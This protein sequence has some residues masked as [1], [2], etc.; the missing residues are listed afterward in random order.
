MP[1]VSVVVP[2][3]NSVTTIASALDSILQQSYRDLEIIAVYDDSQD[4]TLAVMEAIAA[5]DPRLLIFRNPDA[6][7]WLRRMPA[8]LNFGLRHS[9]GEFIARMDADDIAL[10]DRIASQVTFLDQNP[11]V[12]LCG[13]SITL[14][15]R[16]GQRV[17][18]IPATCGTSRTRI[19][20]GYA[21]PLYHPTWMFR[22]SIL[23][24]LH[25]YRDMY[26]EDYDFQLRALDAG[27]QLDNLP[28][29]GLLYRIYPGHRSSL[30]SQKSNRFAYRMHRMRQ[31]KLA[32]GFSVG[33]SRMAIAPGSWPRLEHLAHGVMQ[34][35]FALEERNRIMGLGLIA[36]SLVAL[37]ASAGLTMRKVRAVIQLWLTR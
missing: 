6:T 18:D 20:A 31:R 34:R 8:A 3:Y 27:F 23:E 26:A 24:T 14:I 7:G 16:D 37:P 29:V 12:A 1:R 10:P 2:V 5:R 22:R 30:L 35:G 13:M 25:G 11:N 33:A 15:N 9:E 19:L 28:A 4:G 32:D 21:P 17:R 36:L